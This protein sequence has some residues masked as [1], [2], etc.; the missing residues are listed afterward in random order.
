MCYVKC[1]ETHTNTIFTNSQYLSL[2]WLLWITARLQVH[3]LGSISEV[4]NLGEIS[5]CS[6]Y[7]NNILLTS[8]CHSVCQ[9]S[10]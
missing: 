10:W 7:E 6:E 1:S 4:H 5:Q 2:M 9:T 3:W 8:K